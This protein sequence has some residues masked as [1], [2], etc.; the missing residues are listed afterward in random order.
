MTDFAITNEY[1]LEIKNEKYLTVISWKK[2]NTDL[3]LRITLNGDFQIW[4]NKVMIFRNIQTAPIVEKWNA[5]IQEMER[6]K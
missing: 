5:I 4:S 2:P 1:L 6:V 3:E